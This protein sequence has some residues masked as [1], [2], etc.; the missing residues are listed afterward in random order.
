[1]VAAAVRTPPHNLVL[2]HITDAGA[3][4]PLARDV[5]SRFGVVPGAA[6]PQPWSQ[7]FAERWGSLTGHSSRR[8]M[9]MR[10]H[11]A[12]AVVMPPGVPGE[13]RRA[14][15][16]DRGLLIDWVRAFDREALGTDDAEGAARRVDSHLTEPGRALY[17]WHDDRPVA[18]AG[19]AGPT[20]N[21]IRVVAVYTPPDLRGRGYASA[22]V[23]TLT[24][25]L[26]NEGRAFCFLFTDLANPTSNRVYARLG[27]QPVC[28]VD[29]YQFTD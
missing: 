25:R 20:P 17:L 1:M 13:L 16:A 5:L 26:L 4:D 27:Y 15:H 11:Q 9:A 24:Q 21:G 23:G 7:A 14:E 29:E 18:M 8:G 10:I 3:L 28:D 12:D 6:G 2:S 22:C 19:S